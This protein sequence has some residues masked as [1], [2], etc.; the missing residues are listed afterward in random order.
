VA[1]LS[2]PQLKTYGITMGEF[3]AVIQK[4]SVASSM[5]PN[6]I[7]LSYDELASILAGALE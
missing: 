2:I 6:P 5:K 7:E 4:A 1:E 3:A